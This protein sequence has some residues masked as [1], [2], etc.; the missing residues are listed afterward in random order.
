MGKESI[1]I[2]DY[3]SVFKWAWV[4][5]L[6]WDRKPR[7]AWIW[8]IILLPVWISL[9]YPCDLCLC[10]REHSRHISKW[11]LY[12]FLNYW[13]HKQIF[14]GSSPWMP[15]GVTGGRN[16]KSVWASVI[17]DHRIYF[18]IKLFHTDPP[19]VHE[20]WVLLKILDTLTLFPNKLFSG[21]IL[22]VTLSLQISRWQFFLW[23]QLSD[24][25]SGVGYLQLVFFCMFLRLR[26][27][28]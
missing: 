25:P 28:T 23:P 3:S 6:R 10:Y 15:N 21:V 27:T 24:G 7:G 18:T 4:P 17:L 14:L 19:V 2:F 12:F 13:K 8:I 20:N 16:C 9:W 5:W 26:V 22:C 11:I 1:L